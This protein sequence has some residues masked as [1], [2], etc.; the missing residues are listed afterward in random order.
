M[1][2]MNCPEFANDCDFVVVCLVVCC[3]LEKFAT[4]CIR[5]FDFGYENSDFRL[6]PISGND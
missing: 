4:M 1:T 3:A 6:E 2:K 5:Y